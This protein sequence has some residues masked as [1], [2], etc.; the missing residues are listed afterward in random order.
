V[1]ELGNIMMVE[2]KIRMFEEMFDVSQI[3][4]DQVVH[5]DNLIAFLKESVTQVR[6]DETC[7][8]CYKDLFLLSH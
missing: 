1:H 5:G 4:G 6:A 8:S 3:P 2:F 7:P